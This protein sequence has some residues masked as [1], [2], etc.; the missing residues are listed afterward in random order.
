G[1]VKPDALVAVCVERCLNMMVG[2]LA[3]LKAVG[4]YVSINPTYPKERI[5]FMLEDS[6]PLVLL[7][8]GRLESLFAGMT[9]TLPAIDLEAGF[10]LWAS[11]RH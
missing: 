7:T 6:A 8:Q 1:G 10:P 5:A 2:L 3:I 4:A 11:Q 9:K